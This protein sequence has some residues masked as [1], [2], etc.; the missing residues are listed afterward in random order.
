MKWY[1][2]DGV[3]R[4][5]H[6]TIFGY[7]RRNVLIIIAIVVALIILVIGLAVRLSQKHRNSMLLPL[8]TVSNDSQSLPLPGDTGG[9]YS[10][11]LTYYAPGLGS[12]GITSTDKDLICAISHKLYGT[13]FRSSA[14]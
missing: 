9:I 7:R 1:Y 4:K 6:P 13:F 2:E 5:P 8:T 14:D 3:A 12:C 11:D 10:G